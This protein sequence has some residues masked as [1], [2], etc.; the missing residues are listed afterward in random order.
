MSSLLPR[1]LIARAAALDAA[2][3][4]R[5]L[6][7]QCVGFR[8]W[9]SRGNLGVVENVLLDERGEPREL[10]VRRGLVSR[11]RTTIWA[12]DVAL[13]D[14]ARRAVFAETAAARTTPRPGSIALR[15][16]VD[17]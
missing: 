4:H 17:L 12:R 14:E 5:S 8:V 6:L 1:A 9:T 10:V 2:R 15:Q 7:S 16:V 3:R 11:R 13:V